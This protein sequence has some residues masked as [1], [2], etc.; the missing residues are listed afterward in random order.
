MLEMD[1]A[2]ITP[3]DV[4]KTSGHVDKFSDWMV[5]DT[6]TGDI[7][8]ADHLVEAVLEGRLDGDKQAENNE[9]NATSQKDKKKKKGAV[10]AVKL[11]DATKM[12]Y[13]EILAKAILISQKITNTIDSL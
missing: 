13:E 6:K 10:Q 2:I 7:F 11:D 12:E 3:A 4:L 1:G 8:R 9:N 5:K